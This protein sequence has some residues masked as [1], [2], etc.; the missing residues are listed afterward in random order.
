MVHIHNPST[1]EEIAETGGWQEPSLCCLESQASLGC[2][3][4][5][6]LKTSESIFY[7]FLSTCPPPPPCLLSLPA[8]MPEMFPK[9]LSKSWS[10][11]SLTHCH[12][13]EIKPSWRPLYF[14]IP[15]PRQLLCNQSQLPISTLNCLWSRRAFWHTHH[16]TSTERQ[17]WVY[18]WFLALKKPAN[19][20]TSFLIFCLF[21]FITQ[22]D[23]ELIILLPQPPECWDSA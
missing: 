10:R 17:T 20:L 9:H 19:H 8:L 2:I 22:V 21:C 18:S 15:I 16:V 11:L 12:W 7:T 5:P 6:C 1:G 23:L 3:M 4:R 13:Q 14:W